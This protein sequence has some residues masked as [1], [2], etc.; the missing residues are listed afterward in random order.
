[1]QSFQ[2]QR[3]E[4]AA[5][6]RAERMDF[7]DD[8]VRDRFQTLACPTCKHQVQRFGRR[9]EEVGRFSE[10]PLTFLSGGVAGADGDREGTERLSLGFSRR[11]DSGKRLLQISKDVLVERF[12]RR[13]VENANPS[14]GS[15]DPPEMVETSQKGRKSLTR[16]GRGEDQRVF[17][18][19]HRRPTQPLRRRRN[20]DRRSKPRRNLRKQ[21]VETVGFVA[22]AVDHG[23]LLGRTIRPPSRFSQA[24]G[25][26]RKGNLDG[27]SDRSR[28]TFPGKRSVDEF[29]KDLTD[30]LMPV[31][32][33]GEKCGCAILR[34]EKPDF[35][36]VVVRCFELRRPTRQAL[37]GSD[38]GSGPCDRGLKKRRRR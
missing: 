4:D 15:R 11:K 27:C 23:T 8:D 6:V 28:E 30:R 1:M 20:P 32:G 18:P 22:R 37:K 21:D 14:I 13:D 17:A 24:S 5:F 33:E 9:D 38:H 36:H 16:A 34:Q 2:E 26:N 25:P 31:L 7:I 10:Q 3:Q 12:E 29:A 19:S 35:H